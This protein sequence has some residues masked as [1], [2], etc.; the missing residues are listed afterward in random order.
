MR[1]AAGSLYPSEL[2]QVSETLGYQPLFHGDQDNLPCSHVP[3]LGRPSCLCVKQTTG[4]DVDIHV[5]FLSHGS[6]VW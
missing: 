3:G 5:S 4:R 2:Q 6:A 1:Y